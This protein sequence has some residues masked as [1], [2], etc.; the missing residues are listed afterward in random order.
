M[1]LTLRNSKPALLYAIV[2]LFFFGCAAHNGRP[3]LYPDDKNLTGMYHREGAEEGVFENGSIRVTVRNV[4]ASE[5]EG[6]PLLKNLSDKKYVILSVGIENKSKLKAIYN[7]SMTVLKDDS[8]DYKKPLD[9]TDLYDAAIG[10]SGL[11]SGLSAM[12][13]RFYDLALTLQPGEKTTRFLIFE[14]LSKNAARADLAINE[15]YL[16]TDTV[17]LR[18]P[19]IFKSA[20]I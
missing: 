6:I 18:F 9:Y 14:P 4:K 17:S 20:G 3:Y 16:G 8:M 15:I 19:F 12:K 7:P 11:E 13:G 5:C 2:L 10:D 1:E